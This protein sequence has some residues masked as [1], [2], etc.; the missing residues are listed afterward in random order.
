METVFGGHPQPCVRRQAVIG[1]E[2]GHPLRSLCKYLESMPWCLQHDLK[3]CLDEAVRDS[4]VEQITHGVDEEYTGSPPSEWIAESFRVQSDTETI[5]VSLHT[6]SPQAAGHRLSIAVGAPRRHL[7]A[8]GGWIP[9]QLRPLNRCLRTHGSSFCKRSP[10]AK[11]TI[12]F[13]RV[14]RASRFLTLFS[15]CSSL[16]AL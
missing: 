5:L 11:C 10:C 9:G 16:K 4:L 13:R 7:T 6:H 3:N 8:A 14:P 1:A 12:F 15:S 2:G